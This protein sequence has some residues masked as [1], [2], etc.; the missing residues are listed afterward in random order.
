M[1]TNNM[2]LLWVESGY[3]IHSISP[4]CSI[5]MVN[6]DVYALTNYCFSQ[7]LN[8]ALKTSD[9]EKNEAQDRVNELQTST[10]SLQSAKRKAEQQLATL[11]EE[12]EDMESEA[13]ENGEKLRKA[14]E[15]NARFQSEQISTK[16][17]LSSVE[18][19][20]VLQS[21]MYCMDIQKSRPRAQPS[22]YDSALFPE[23]NAH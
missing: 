18:K 22:L 4:G 19:S 15:Q 12:Y 9:A 13:R 5:G 23:Q 6:N 21:S 1:L 14:M 2:L 3:K 8:R 16:G 7:Q 11:Q 17:Q 20:K 10:T